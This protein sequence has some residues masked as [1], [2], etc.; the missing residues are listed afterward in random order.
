VLIFKS[1]TDRQ[2]AERLNGGGVGVLPTDTLYGLVARAAD[3]QATAR[4]YALKHRDHKPGTVIAAN[5]GQLIQLGVSKDYLQR[6]AKWWPNSL[7]VEIPLGDDLA[8]LHQSTGRQ[9]FRVV[10]DETLRQLLLQTGPLLTSSANQPG[11]PV[12][13][14]IKEAQAYFGEQVDFYVDGGDLSGRPPSTLIKV[15]NEGIEVIRP[16]AVDIGAVEPKP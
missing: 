15:T 10:P 7:S 2:L 11:E 1:L 8:Y 3:K 14:N 9:G 4:L 6:V 13:N 5:V 16:G 12:S